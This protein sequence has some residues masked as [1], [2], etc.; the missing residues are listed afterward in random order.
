MVSMKEQLDKLV[1]E[2]PDCKQQT[3]KLNGH[4]IYKKLN[5][6][7]R[8]LPLQSDIIGFQVQCINPR[9]GSKFNQYYGDKQIYRA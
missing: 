8:L 7:V 2:C 9:C 4:V 3:L 1:K 5:W 6:R